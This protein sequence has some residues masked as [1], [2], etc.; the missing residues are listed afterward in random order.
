MKS[1]ALKCLVATGLMA[2]A[3]LAQ[4]TTI[5]FDSLTNPGPWQYNA[6]S[7]AQQGF[8]F[9]STLANNGYS[10]YSYGLASPY[11]ADAAGATLS[12]N[13]DGQALV[14]SRT[15]GGTFSL[16]SFDLAYNDNPARGS[17]RFDYTDAQ[18]THTTQLSFADAFTL[19]T[20]TFDYTGL[21]S[22]ALWDDDF[23]LDNLVV[24]AQASAVPEPASWALLL[25][26]GLALVAR[27]RK[28]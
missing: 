6:D 11:N 17:V 22:F 13:D 18:G 9:A 23:Q 25:V 24:N 28:A 4:A 20:F 19:H 8:T 2:A 16:A 10:L 15:G 3:G 1:N 27:R 14:V 26:G 5:D 21:T 7:F 12:E